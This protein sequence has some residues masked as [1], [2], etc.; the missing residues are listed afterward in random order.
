MA[1]AVGVV[2][3][4]PGEANAAAPLSPQGTDQSAT[5][6]GGDAL[7]EAEAL[8]KAEKSGEPVEIASL[9]GETSEVFAT[10]EGYLEAREYLRPVWAR[11]GSTWARVDT[12]LTVTGEGTVTPKVVT[13]DVE[14]SGGGE[15]PLVQIRRAGRELSMSWPRPLPKPQLEGPVA[16]YPSV[17]PDVDLR[18]TAQADGFTQL[19]VVKTVEAAAN[20]ELAELR[21]GLQAQGL[22]VKETSAGGLQAL[23]KGAN[24]PVFEAPKPMMW[25]SSP[26]ETPTST[27]APLTRTD[28]ATGK[29][30]SRASAIETD[31]TGAEP[32]PGEPGKLAPVDVEVPAGQDVLVLTPD[33]D[34]LRGE[35]TTYPVFIDPQWYSPQA[36]A[37]TMVSKYWADSPQWKFNGDPDAGMG[38]C[39]WSYCQPNDTK[40]LLYRIPV[41]RFAGKSVLSAEFVVRN[42]WSA[43]CSA[44]AVDLYQTKNISSSTTWNDQYANGFWIK[45]LASESFA[46]GYSGCAAKDA[47]FDVKSAVQTAADNKESTMTFGLKAASES[48]AYGWKRFSDKAFLRVMYNRP[49]PQINMSQLTM[50]YGGTCKKPADKAR[51]R[52]LGKIYA[53]NVTDPDG[54]AVAVQFQAKWD[55]GDGKGLIARWKPTLTSSKKSGSSFSISLPASVPQN[56]NVNWYARSYDGA[57]YSPWSYAGDPTACYFVYDTNV[58]KAP[59][60]SSA[61][62]PASN[63]EDP[64]D[65]W[66][67]GVGQYGSFQLTAANSDVTKYWFGINGDPT[68]KNAVTTSGGAARTMRMLPAKPG[69]NFVTAQ[70]FDSAGNGSEVRTYQF[71]VKAG[72]PE[73][74]MW[75]LDDSAGASQA[76]GTAP[77]RTADLKGGPTPGVPGAKGTAVTFDGIDDYAVT[78]I[79]TVDTS[80]GFSVSAWVK[81]SRMP[82]QAAIVAAQ[83]GNHSPGFELYYSQYYDRWAFNQYRADTPDAGIAR[84]M[85]ASPGGAKVGEWTHL[86]GAFD[87]N[88]DEL[89]LYVNGE[90]AGTKVYDSPWDARRGLQIGAGSYSGELASFFPGTIDDVQIFDKAILAS[91]VTQLYRKESLTSG[92]PARALFTMDDAADA[93]QLT[94]GALVPDAT[95]VGGATPGGTG[96]AGKALTLDG[97]DDYATTG[98]PLLNNRRGFAVSAWA[99]LPETK[100]NH[101]AIVATQTST[102]RPGM[103]LYYSKGYDRWVFNQYSANSPNATP[104][105][106]MQADGKTAYGGQWTHLVGVQDTVTNKLVLYVNGV[107]A[108]ETDIQASWYAGGAVQIGAGSYDGKPDSFFPGQIDDVRFFDRPVS[109]EEVQ[110]LFKQRPLVKGRWR[111]DTASG[112]PLVTPDASASGNAMTLSGGAQVGSG[113]VDGGVMLDGVDDYGVTAAVPVDTS[114]S[115]TVAAFAQAAA[116]PEE[117]VTLLS[118]P[119]AQQNAFT[120]RYEPSAT[121]GTD[122][123]RWR[124]GMASSDGSAADIRQVGNGQF[125]GPTEWTHVALVYD[126]FSKQL[127]LYVNGEL[128]VRACTDAEGD[129]EADDTT[130]TD[131]ISWADDVLSFKATQPMQLGRAKTETN[132]WGELYWDLWSP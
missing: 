36:T 90:L 71:R 86:V 78:D 111:F 109:A 63:P 115:F 107:K 69:L 44:R 4:L 114:A 126:G 68:S 10:A 98:R 38:Y 2:P 122:A 84:A 101:A 28:E 132:T 108:G 12:D 102:S 29:V 120:V 47:E 76:Q 56:T 34:V 22:T 106:A 48:D 83:P 129:G 75:Q 96:I 27:N 104:I 30:S 46:Y 57:Q 100:P 59:T 45:K 85:Q 118:V 50:E 1:L 8:A 55:V 31:A 52:T 113:W 58:P 105:R 25:D 37:W 119:G 123:G 53:N 65:P 87:V 11:K 130:C 91:E 61:E 125:F 26:G 35:G 15:G 80:W 9:R 79:P 40:R 94:G 13:T 112:S 33:A 117:G 43:S 17:L 62:Y 88:G 127:L 124:I 66:L 93:T 89:R 49:P 39:N 6:G 67:D 5:G 18:M 116:A 131:Q 64:D 103:E 14:F 99:K 73:R 16:T 60:I 72:Q 82:D 21:L 20:P 19:L 32:G 121:P 97:I 92:R 77:A 41:S 7:T 51:V 23:D 95:F 54:D 3:A 74:A 128:E 81:L 42:T 110:Q 24:G 70:A